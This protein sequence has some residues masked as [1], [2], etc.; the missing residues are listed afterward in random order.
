MNHLSIKYRLLATFSTLAVLTIILTALSLF[1]LSN[2]KGSFSNYLD[3]LRARADAAEQVRSMVDRRAIAIRNLVIVSKTENTTMEKDNVFR[4]DAQAK[5]DIEKLNNLTLSSQDMDAEERR[6][7]GEINRINALYMEVAADIYKDALAGSH[8]QALSKIED[9]CRP[10]LA[11]LEKTTDDYLTHIHNLETS[12]R[13]DLDARYAVQRNIQ[14]SISIAA[15]ILAIAASIVITR[16]IVRPLGEALEFTKVVAQ[17]DLT[18]RIDKMA[19]DE[20]GQLLSALSN[21]ADSLTQTVGQVRIGADMIA[22]ASSEIASGNADLSSRT[23]SQASSLAETASSMEQLTATVKQNAANAREA[24]ELVISASHVAQRGGQVV[25][26]VVE[27]MGSIKNS[28]RKIVDIISVIDGIAFQTNILALNAAVEAA[29]AGEQGRGFAV[30]AT[31]VRNLAQRS[32]ASAKEIKSLIGDSVNMIDVGGKLV[33]EAG[34]TMNEI[35]ESV[36]QVADIMNQ[37][38]N[39]SEEQSTGI[40]QVNLTI[41][42]MDQITQQNAALVEQA[43]ASAQ[44]MQD[45]AGTLSKAVG[46]FKLTHTAASFAEKITSLPNRKPIA[47]AIRQTETAKKISVVR[48]TPAGS[49]A[50]QAD[51]WEEF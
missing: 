48:T 33:D 25:N 1:S 38:T 8:D 37:I 47:K 30:V 11:A 36:K 31:E 7:T 34:V 6:L 51:D 3:G 17:G 14:I 45:Q 26:Q 46:M 13:L 44:S 10:L 18:A 21:M 19:K 28:S 4:F 12:L 15:I 49:K 16:S 39:A 23:E 5:T 32:A 2:I 35:V 20:T 43:A 9:Q 27:T 41:T 22:T 42:Q 50:N 29:R 24:N 40:E